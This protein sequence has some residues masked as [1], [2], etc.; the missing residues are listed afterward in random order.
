VVLDLAGGPYTAASVHA[1]ASRAR[2]ILIGTMA[3]GEATLPL[4]LVLG[5]RLTIRGTVLRA[6]ALEDRILA[7]RA[8]ASQVVPLLARGL[9][10]PV[11]DRVLPLE[12]IAEGHAYLESNATFGKVV[13]EIG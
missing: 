8:F 11:V 1:G 3:G 10:R 7:S 4:G 12:R 13:L 6:R 2:I 5:K 9:V